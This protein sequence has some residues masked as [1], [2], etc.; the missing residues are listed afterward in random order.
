[1][2]ERDERIARLRS[3]PHFVVAVDGPSGAGKSTT[4]KLLAEALGID[5][6]D[7]GAMYR[8]VGLKFL[9]SGVQDSA[10]DFEERIGIVLAETAIDLDGGRIWLDRED[11]SGLIRTPEI[12]MAASKYSAL[13][14]VREKLVS[15]QRDMGARKSV[16]MDGRDIGTNVF[17]EAR[18]KFF[19]TASS[20][21]RA[22]RRHK[23]LLEKGMHERL[24]DV[25]A[26]IEKRDQDD[27]ERELNPLAR[28]AD[29]VL[30]VTDNFGIDE[31]TDLVLDE[32]DRKT[33]GQ[34]LDI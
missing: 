3:L 30:L 28:A 2:S 12:T 26:D 10:A 15:L 5:Y 32:M 11:V 4:A 25:L 27:S 19:I 33:S 24:D 21:T 6:I 8:A 29:A 22:K 16:V 23:E 13:P 9:K 31:V 14:Q 7:T 20:E 1:L 18:F 17:P 34:S